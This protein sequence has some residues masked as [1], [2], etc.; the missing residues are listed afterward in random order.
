MNP[1]QLP[2]LLSQ[3]QLFAM[4]LSVLVGILAIIGFVL[5]AAK[6]AYEERRRPY[7]PVWR[8]RATVLF[9]LAPDARRSDVLRCSL[10]ENEP[11]IGCGK[12]CL[13]AAT[14]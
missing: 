13:H 7:C 2:T 14:K 8:S 5:W 1:Q 4:L 11:P 12:E 3:E 10:F 9:R 6:H